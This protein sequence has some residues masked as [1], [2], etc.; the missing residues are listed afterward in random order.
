MSDDRAGFSWRRWLARALA[1]LARHLLNRLLEREKM[2]WLKLQHLELDPPSH[3]LVATLLLEGEAD[4]VTVT[5]H[6]RVEETGIMAERVETSKP[7]LGKLAMQWRDSL[8]AA[9][10][11]QAASH[12]TAFGML[13]KLL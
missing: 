6:Y 4:P 5:L 2:D 1:P 12:P 13:R 9:L 10:A 8:N 11:E 7:W 3:R